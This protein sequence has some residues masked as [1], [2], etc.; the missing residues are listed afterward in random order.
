MA[1]LNGRCRVPSWLLAV[2]LSVVSGCS[3]TGGQGAAGD[4]PCTPFGDTFP[5]PIALGTVLGIGRHA[6]G[7]VYVLDETSTGYRAFVSGY[8][9]AFSDPVTLYRKEISG[10]GSGARDAG[11]WYV[12]TVLDPGAPFA[13]KVDDTS[14]ALRMGVVRGTFSDRDFVIGETGDVL[15]VQTAEEIA[16][17]AV[18]DLPDGDVVEYG[19]ALPDGRDLAVIRP[20]HDWS[21]EDF[22]LFLGDNKQMVER[23]VLS[24]DRA[25]DG[26]TTTI[27]F[28][29]DG[30]RATAYFP[31]P[32]SGA[33]ASLTTTGA[34]VPLTI[35]PA[36]SAP[37]TLTYLCLP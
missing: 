1:L 33:G 32:I 8:G 5:A 37:V 3:E 6:D 16:G 35:A 17:L 13:L 26:G 2:G 14:G 19:A 4:V 20:A 27:V 28:T 25:R 34:T 12:V 22:R 10:S 9:L 11:H 31:A 18:R 30:A 36:G 23:P 24:V 21:Y 29:L 7:T 15:T